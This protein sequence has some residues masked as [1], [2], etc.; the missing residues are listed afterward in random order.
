VEELFRQ[1]NS[2]FRSEGERES[3]F[4]FAEAFTLNAARFA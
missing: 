1:F 3:G 2:G 4:E